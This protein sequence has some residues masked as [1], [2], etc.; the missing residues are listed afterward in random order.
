MNINLNKKI[1]GSVDS[2]RDSVN[3]SVWSSVRD[4]VRDSAWDSVS[5]SVRDS[6]WESVWESVRDTVTV[7]DDIK[8]KKLNEY[9][10]K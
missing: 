2:V 3:D 9:R 1:R 7:R 10:F 4:S 5:D 6:V 8:T